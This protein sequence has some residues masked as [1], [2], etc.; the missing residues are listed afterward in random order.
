V[1]GGRVVGSGWCGAGGGRGRGGSRLGLG[2][3][4]VRGRGVRYFYF[5]EVGRIG[6]NVIWWRKKAG[7]GERLT[8]PV[9]KP[10][11]RGQNVKGALAWDCSADR[12]LLK[13]CY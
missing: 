4:A 11:V 6:W 10:I 5:F 7:L 9:V 12:R 8:K 1:R 13:H 3:L 2:R